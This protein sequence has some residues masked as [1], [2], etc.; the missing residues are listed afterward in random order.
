M[1]QDGQPERV[2]NLKVSLWELDSAAGIEVF[3]DPEGIIRVLVVRPF[4]GNSGKALE[5]HN[6]SIGGKAI[7]R[8][9]EQGFPEA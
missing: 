5:R 4:Q 9:F 2:Y 3:R 7:S 8:S 6:W 1:Q